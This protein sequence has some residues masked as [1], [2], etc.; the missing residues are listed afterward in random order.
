MIG[1]HHFYCNILGGNRTHTTV[2]LPI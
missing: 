1:N 2:R